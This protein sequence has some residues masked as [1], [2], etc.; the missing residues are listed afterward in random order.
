MFEN[1]YDKTAYV[2]CE[3]VTREEDLKLEILK[4]DTGI[5]PEG[6]NVPIITAKTC[7]QS[8]EVENWN[9][10]IYGKELVMSSLDNDGMIQNDIKKGQWIGEFGH[11]L[12]TSPRRQMVFYPPTSSHRILKYWN[13][14]NLLEAN[15][16]T[17]PYGY[18]FAMAQNALHGVP[19]AFSLRSLGSVDLATRRVKAPLKILTYDSVYRPSHIEAYGNEII[20]ESAN[21]YMKTDHSIGEIMNEC[22]MLE[23]IT[24]SAFD[25]SEIVDYVTN[26]SENLQVMAE[27]LNLDY[28]D[29]TLT[30]GGTRMELNVDDHTKVNIPIES[31]INMQY[32]DILSGIKKSY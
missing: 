25:L 2:M 31:A 20:N 12:D 15:V 30:E 19:W 16:Q 18:G 26:H 13:T 11:P 27:M 5:T 3:C 32:A 9:K 22:S 1:D 21:V 8:F 29:A 10:R 23:P 6:N 17:L 7:L 14:G 24:E 4:E 28:I